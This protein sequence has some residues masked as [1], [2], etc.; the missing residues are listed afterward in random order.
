MPMN[1]KFGIQNLN[2][3]PHGPPLQ[4]GLG[5]RWPDSS[6]S[7]VPTSDYNI[8]CTIKDQ[9]HQELNVSLVPQALR[10]ISEPQAAPILS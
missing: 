2:G 3:L 10:A 4:G 9:S 5:Q 1:D 8:A 7:L 6:T